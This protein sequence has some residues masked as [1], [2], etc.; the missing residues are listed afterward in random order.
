MAL[1]SG[2]HI[3]ELPLQVSATSHALTEGLQ[4]LAA[5]STA[6]DGHAAAL[7]VQ[8]SAR[9]QGPDAARHS[10]ELDATY[11]LGAASSALV[12]HRPRGQVD[13]LRATEAD[14]FRASNYSLHFAPRSQGPG[15]F[16]LDNGRVRGIEF[17]REP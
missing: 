12:V 13:T 5:V 1:A 11:E 6:S 3:A 15:S 14:V 17:V 10:V 16:A 8:L 4:T 2:G 7:P 9:S